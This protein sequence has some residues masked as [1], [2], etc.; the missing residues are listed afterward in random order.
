MEFVTID[1]GNVDRYLSEIAD[2]HY[3]ALFMRL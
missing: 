1:T 2:I 3:P